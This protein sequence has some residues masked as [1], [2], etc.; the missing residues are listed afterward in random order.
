M[1]LLWSQRLLKTSLFKYGVCSGFTYVLF[2]A[3]VFLLHYLLGWT[4]FFSVALAHVLVSV[5]GFILLRTIVF[6]LYGLPKEAG[7]AIILNI[8]SLSV[9][10]LLGFMLD[11]NDWPPHLSFGIPWVTLVQN[12]L[13]ARYY[14]WPVHPPQR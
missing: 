13:I 8:L 7:R 1:I 10:L 2:I 4:I 14:V 6:D 3:S 9:A 12:Y 5:C 11:A